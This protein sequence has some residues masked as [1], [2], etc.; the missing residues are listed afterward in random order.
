M[1][2]PESTRAIQAL[3]TRPLRLR[4]E[5]RARVR[6][7]QLRHAF[8]F[9]TAG[10]AQRLVDPGAESERWRAVLRQGFNTFVP[11][12]D[13]KWACTEPQPGELRY[14]PFD[15]SL[16]WCEENGYST[17][18][19]C[20]FYSTDIHIQ[21]WVR[22]LNDRDLRAALE[23]RARGVAR[24]YRGRVPEYDLS[25]E[26]LDDVDYFRDRLGN[27]IVRDMALWVKDE[28]PDARLF[29]N[30]HDILTGGDVERYVEL[31]ELLLDLGVP[32]DGIGCQGHFDHP[33]DAARVTPALDR[34]GQ[35]G[36]PIK[37]TEFDIG[38]PLR[39]ERYRGVRWIRGAEK[40][41]DLARY[42]AIL[43]EHGAEYEA[44]RAEALRSIYTQLFAH[45]R[46]QGIVMWGFWEGEHWRGKGGLWRQD[47]Q[48]LPA[49]QVYLD[50]VRGAWWTA[51]DVELADD[52]TAEI[53]VFCGR[54]RLQAGSAT[55]THEIPPASDPLEIR[56]VP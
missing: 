27:E 51:A 15:R 24:R 11:G 19:H 2:D 56:L 31:I 4:G 7:E 52:G 5:P 13:F 46:V 44:A 49:G 23:A 29:L 42:Q 12:N 48:P 14:E 38:I 35:F 6:V 17:R 43:G 40:D 53:D 34:L 30:E 55:S 21:P 50:L 45:P 47:F 20:I 33:V 22:A 54:Y 18:G 28:D 39:L 26:M 8:S 36:L 1:S 16:A 9:G 3:R 32:I 25:N 37:V 10:S 41:K